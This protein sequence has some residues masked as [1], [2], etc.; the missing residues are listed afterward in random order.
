MYIFVIIVS[1]SAKR[2]DK[3]K[4]L[5]SQWLWKE[6]SFFNLPRV[7]DSLRVYMQSGIQMREKK[8]K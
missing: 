8:L 6:K 4:Y 5:I 1:G 2:N 3:R 7:E